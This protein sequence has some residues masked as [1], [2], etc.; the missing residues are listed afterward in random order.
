M[1]VKSKSHRV[2]YTFRQYLQRASPHGI[3]YLSHA[4]STQIRCVWRLVLALALGC[5]A[6]MMCMWLKARRDNPVATSTRSEPA[7]RLPFPAI[8]FHPRQV[9]EPKVSEFL[10]QV[11]NLVDFDCVAEDA[12]KTS[13]RRT[14]E[15]MRPMLNERLADALR[16]AFDH[17]LRWV[18]KYPPGHHFKRFILC[19]NGGPANFKGLRRAMMLPEWKGY[20]G[21]TKSKQ[22]KEILLNI[23][24]PRFRLNFT[25]DFTEENTFNDFLLKEVTDNGTETSCQ[26]VMRNEYRS[27]EML[28]NTLVAFSL[29]TGASTAR[30]PLGT[31][32]HTFFNSFASKEFPLAQRVMSKHPLA[33][34]GSLKAIEFY[35][36][37]HTKCNSVYNHCNSDGFAGTFPCDCSDFS[38]WK[39]RLRDTARLNDAFDVLSRSASPVTRRFRTASMRKIAKEAIVDE[40][41]L[42][43]ESLLETVDPQPLIWACSVNG[44]W[45]KSCFDFQLTYSE[46]GL[47]Y[48]LNAENAKKVFNE[49]FPP[50]LVGQDDGKVRLTAKDSV[51]LMV[52]IPK[53]SR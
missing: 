1:A 46:T 47:G 3:Q 42:S 17:V 23:L 15:V 19:Q 25:V 29:L 13:C 45:L 12:K 33:S 36:Y 7:Y 4:H 18:R 10:K 22:L 43:E 24:L 41:D 40:L 16:K 51:T 5:G 2:G 8:T 32:L 53:E 34:N 49:R 37:V 6:Y 26:D 20:D 27:K 14:A 35:S 44:K 48:V 21:L 50:K 31:F 39:E 28:I 11:F 38:A 52:T 9:E 30:V